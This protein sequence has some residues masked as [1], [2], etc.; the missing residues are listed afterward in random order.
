MA[1]KPVFDR[2]I[3]N[4]PGVGARIQIN[5]AIKE[6]F[7]CLDIFRRGS[8]ILV[9][10]NYFSSGAH[11]SKISG[12]FFFDSVLICFRKVAIGCLTGVMML[13]QLSIRL[14]FARK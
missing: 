4:G 6:G 9:V 7:D 3:D 13:N 5:L 8:P 10:C 14:L 12:Q 2:G 1:R 11:A